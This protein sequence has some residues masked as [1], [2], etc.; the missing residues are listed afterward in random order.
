[1]FCAK[2]WPR[3]ETFQQELQPPCSR[4]YYSRCL[5]NSLMCYSCTGQK[6]VQGVLCP[7]CTSRGFIK[8]QIFFSLCP[9]LDRQVGDRTFFTGRDFSKELNTNCQHSCFPHEW[10]CLNFLH[11]P[12]A[13][14]VFILPAEN[15]YFLRSIFHSCFLFPNLSLLWWA[16][17]IS[18]LAM[19]VGEMAAFSTHSS[20]SSRPLVSCSP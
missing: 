8:L 20:T 5:S 19:V 17:Y 7:R 18:K 2:T 10:P 4:C 14:I 9:D 11:P 12:P 6:P 1:M 13:D 16:Q 15:I 3:W